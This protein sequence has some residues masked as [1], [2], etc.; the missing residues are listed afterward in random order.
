MEFLKQ[1]YLKEIASLKDRIAYCKR[2]IRLSSEKWSV[3]EYNELINNYENRIS[4]LQDI[5][6][7]WN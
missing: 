5:L 7:N 2:Q 3:K 1:D 6:F 4:E